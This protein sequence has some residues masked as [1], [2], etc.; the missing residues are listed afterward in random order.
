[1][2]EADVVDGPRVRNDT[3]SGERLVGVRG[4]YDNC[5]GQDSAS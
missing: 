4:A 5:E 2:E 1:M 3:Y